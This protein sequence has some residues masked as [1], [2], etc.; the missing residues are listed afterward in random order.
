MHLKMTIIYFLFLAIV[1]GYVV[2][3]IHQ[4]TINTDMS[5]HKLPTTGE[6]QTSEGDCIAPELIQVLK[7]KVDN[8]NFVSTIQY[9]NKINDLKQNE[10]LETQVFHQLQEIADKQRSWHDIDQKHI[11]KELLA[12]TEADNLESQFSF[13]KYYYQIH[14]YPQAIKW[15]ELSANQNNADA[16]KLL[17][18]MYR[19]GNGVEIDYAEAQRWFELAAAQSDDPEV[20]AQLGLYYLNPENEFNN[21]TVDQEKGYYLLKQAAD[22]G[23]AEA[24]YIIANLYFTGQYVAQNYKEAYYWYKLAA[25]SGYHKACIDLGSMYQNGYYAEKNMPEALEYYKK[26]TEQGNSYG[27]FLMG[28]IYENGTG[29]KKDL[30][31]AKEYYQEGAILFDEKSLQRLSELSKK[32]ESSDN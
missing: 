13:G 3:L 23:N 26:S 21:V 18:I 14:D 24:Q 28:Q 2:T 22:S 29:V 8:R 25:T 11:F 31:K 7:Q 20:W 10:D 32:S 9:H 5:S 4:S 30:K 1:S 12:T 6:K 27:F 16:Q 19:D 15:L 17:G